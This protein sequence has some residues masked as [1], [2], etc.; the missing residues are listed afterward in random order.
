[1]LTMSFDIDARCVSTSIDIVD[2]VRSPPSHRCTMCF[3]ID[4]RRRRCA[5]GRFTSS[6]MSS[7]PATTSTT[8]CLRLVHVVIDI[9]TM[10]DDIVDDV[11]GAR[12]HRHRHRHDV[13][14][15]RRRCVGSTCT[16]SPH[17]TTSSTT[18]GDQIHVV[19]DIV[20][21]RDDI[22]DD[23][24]GPCVHRHRHRRDM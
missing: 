10:C 14:R 12:S 5:D 2:D 22:V 8:M 7:R 1:M 16:S 19:V 24:M 15:H 18:C 6:T 11:W 17:A 20:A 3:D 21:V 9:V 23:V 4:R 13:R